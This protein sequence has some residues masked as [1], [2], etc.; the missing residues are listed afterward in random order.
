MQATLN[1]EEIHTEFSRQIDKLLQTGAHVTHIDNH[2]SEIYGM[3]H[4]FEMVLK[5]A[6]SY[7]LPLRFPFGRNFARHLP[8]YAQAYATDEEALFALSRSMQDET[9]RRHI[10]HPDE[11]A[12]EFMFSHATP[13]LY[14][15]ILQR[16]EPG[17]TELCTHPSP[18]DAKGQAEIETLMLFDKK[19]LLE[20]YHIQ[21]VSF[22]DIE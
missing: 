12:P 9:A 3:P 22:Q 4:H 21:L 19:R 15:K 18:E 5:L 14:K 20:K 8:S 17:I 16:L 1:P 6:Q 10:R 2:R 7:H 13:D 11:F